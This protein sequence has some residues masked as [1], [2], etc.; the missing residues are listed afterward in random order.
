MK[1]NNINRISA[2]GLKSIEIDELNIPQIIL[3]MKDH[4]IFK[5]IIFWYEQWLKD[6]TIYKKK[7]IM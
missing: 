1:S 5:N 4:N 7:W 3:I 6:F 2:T